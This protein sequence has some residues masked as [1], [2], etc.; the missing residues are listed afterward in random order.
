L[1]S[2]SPSAATSDQLSD[3]SV[4]T[5]MPKRAATRCRLA[6]GAAAV[7]AVALLALSKKHD[8]LSQSRDACA[9]AG[10]AAVAAANI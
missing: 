9:G 10:L 6:A 5:A 7:A 1:A 3:S 4:G 8:G 2:G